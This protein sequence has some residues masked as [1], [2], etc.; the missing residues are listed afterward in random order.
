MI[1]ISMNVG[2]EREGMEGVLIGASREDCSIVIQDAPK[3]LSYRLATE[4][5]KYWLVS[6]TSG[7]ILEATELLEANNKKGY[8][9]ELIILV[10]K[11]LGK[12]RKDSNGNAGTRATGI[13]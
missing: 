5:E 4:L 7:S 10:S 9:G 2:Q 6:S 13:T 1:I 3:W 8:L 12:P 11:T